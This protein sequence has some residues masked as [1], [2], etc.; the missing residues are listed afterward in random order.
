MS[1]NTFVIDVQKGTLFCHLY[2]NLNK[3][4]NPEIETFSN[5]RILF[6]SAIKF[7]QRF[8]ENATTNEFTQE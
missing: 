7:L 2:L 8:F 6:L 5:F 3:A 4:K 1:Y